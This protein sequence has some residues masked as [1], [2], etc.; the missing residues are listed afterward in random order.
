MKKRKTTQNLVPK[1]SPALTSS[2]IQASSSSTTVLSS[3]PNPEA[4][5]DINELSKLVEQQR[6]SWKSRNKKS[7]S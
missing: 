3:Q 5:S 4:E 1:S 7:R 6:R 2:T